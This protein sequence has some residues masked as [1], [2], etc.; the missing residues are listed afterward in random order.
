M[1]ALYTLTTNCWNPTIIHCYRWLKWSF[2]SLSEVQVYQWLHA[3]RQQYI[4][5]ITIAHNAVGL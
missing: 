4:D 5:R 2:F 3:L 1:C